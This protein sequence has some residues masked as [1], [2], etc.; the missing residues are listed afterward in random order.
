MVSYKR[1]PVSV[2]LDIDDTCD[3]VHGHQQLSL[4]NAHDDERCFLPIHI[5]DTKRSRPVAVI[6]RCGKTPSGVEVRAH[7]A[8]W[9]GIFE[10]VGR[11]PTSYSG[12]DG[13]Y[14]RP[15]AMA[16]CE[17]NGVDYVFGL[18][19]T[20]PLSRKVD[21]ATDAIRT[22]R[23]LDDVRGLRR[24]ATS[25]QI[26]GSRTT[27]HCSY[28]G[29]ETRPRYPRRHQSRSRLARMALRQCL[30]PA[31]TGREPD[32]AA[33]DAAGFRSHILLLRHANQVRL[34]LHTAAY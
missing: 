24:D 20:K 30:L 31:W 2:T 12:G 16:W 25:S 6:L 22:E 26:L 18:S 23:V 33:Q 17:T 21:E 14:A 10:N 1:E 9:C 19:G 5:Y 11:K 13:H 4:F 8:G 28:R 3:V 32:Q 29:D 34:V 7:L 15:E 27:R